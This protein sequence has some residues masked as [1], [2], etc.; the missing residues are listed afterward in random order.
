MSK[1]Q[2]AVFCARS[3]KVAELELSRTCDPRWGGEG[4]ERKADAIW[5]T[6]QYFAGPTISL[7]HWLDI[8]C[9]SG[10]IAA[11]LAPRVSRITGI[12]PEPWERWADWTRACANLSFFQGSYA[13]E[14]LHVASASMDVVICNQVYEHVANPLALVAFIQRVLK[15]GGVCYFAGP[16]L[17]FPIEPHV[18]WPFVHWLPRDLARCVMRVMGS[19]RADELDAYSTH[20]WRL[21]SWFQSGFVITNAVPFITRVVLP[22]QN[23]GLPWRALACLPAWLLDLGTPLSPGLVFVLKKKP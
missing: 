7:G 14:A 3:S 22:A 21:K 9:G 15:P 4:R 11:C 2:R 6:L 19:R 8:G 20:F 1:H 12:D 10:G 18:F 16:N 5:R 23:R 13:D 17:L